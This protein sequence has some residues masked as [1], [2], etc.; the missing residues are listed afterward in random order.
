MGAGTRAPEDQAR[1][2]RGQ[3]ES[4]SRVR[5]PWISSRTA[6][7]GQALEVKLVGLSELRKPPPRERTEQRVHL[8]LRPEFQPEGRRGPG[9]AGRPPRPRAHTLTRIVPS[10]TAR[11]AAKGGPRERAG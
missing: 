9:R 11:R 2:G 6:V 1:G 3:R 4:A 8:R 7:H 10:F 5:S